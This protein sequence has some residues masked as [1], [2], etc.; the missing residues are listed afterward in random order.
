MVFYLLFNLKALKS[1]KKDMSNIY[2]G[3]WFYLKKIQYLR[4]C[5]KYKLIF[6]NFKYNI[7]K[8]VDFYLK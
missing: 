6:F 1:Y 8:N 3:K 4:I 7:N 5:N 2:I